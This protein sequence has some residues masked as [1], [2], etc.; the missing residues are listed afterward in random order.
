MLN[1]Y[2]WCKTP[3]D[4]FSKKKISDDPNFLTFSLEPLVIYNCALYN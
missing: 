3:F 4:R 2:H 1:F